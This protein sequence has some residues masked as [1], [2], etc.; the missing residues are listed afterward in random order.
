MAGNYREVSAMWKSHR[1]KEQT[2]T[3][4]S[5]GVTLVGTEGKCLPE[6]II[7]ELG[8]FALKS[9]RVDSIQSE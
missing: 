1:L 7:F 4:D 3:W 2:V 5:V 6:D 9:G 8:E